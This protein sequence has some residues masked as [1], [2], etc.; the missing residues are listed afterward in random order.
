MM[1]SSLSRG[2]IF[3]DARALRP[4]EAHN[5]KVLLGVD[6]GFR[7]PGQLRVAPMSVGTAEYAHETDDNDEEVAGQLLCLRK[8]TSATTPSRQ[9]HRQ[10]EQRRA[11][12]ISQLIDNMRSE[13]TRASSCDLQLCSTKPDK[14]VNGDATKAEVL[15]AA[16]MMLRM[17][18]KRSRAQ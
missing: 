11:H 16:V 15:E 14:I 10:V 2:R 5:A 4:R 1:P 6:L 3:S 18:R 17:M 8:R 13:L 7:L 9:N 12:Q